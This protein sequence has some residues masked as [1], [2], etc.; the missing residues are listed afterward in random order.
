MRC[1][2]Y[3]LGLTGYDLWDDPNDPGRIM[4]LYIG[5]QRE[6]I[7]HSYKIQKTLAGRLFVRPNRRRIYL[8][9]VLSSNI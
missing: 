7:A 1:G 4:A 2:Y 8:D 6:Q 5:S 9:E 3:S